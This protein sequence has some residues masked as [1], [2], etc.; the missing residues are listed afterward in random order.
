MRRTN[1]TRRSLWLAKCYLLVVDFETRKSYVRRLVRISSVLVSAPSVRALVAASLPRHDVPVPELLLHPVVHHHRAR[2]RDVVARASSGP[3]RERH[4]APARLDDWSVQSV[5]L[6]P[7]NVHRAGRVHEILQRDASHLNGD[8]HR[9]VRRVSREVSP[10]VVL[11]QRQLL[12][13]LRRVARLVLEPRRDGEQKTS[14]ELPRA[15]PQRPDVRLVLRLDDADAEESRAGVHGGSRG[16]SVAVSTRVR[17]HRR[18]FDQ[19]VVVVAAPSAAVVGGAE[20]T[21]RFV[22]AIAFAFARRFIFISAFLSAFLPYFVPLGLSATTSAC[23]S[24]LLGKRR[25]KL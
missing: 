8:P 23:A 24:P 12:V 1:T 2:H 15:P 18:P 21:R 19:R 5:I 22:Y 16:A 9:A 11:E 13:R 25:A 7:E 20:G 6:R 4:V 10:L 3:L 14:A 17:V